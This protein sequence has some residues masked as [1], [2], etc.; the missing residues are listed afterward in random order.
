MPRTNYVPLGPVI[1]F[2]KI[3]PGFPIYQDNEGKT[4]YDLW[5]DYYKVGYRR[6]IGSSSER[7]LSG[8]LLIK[9]SLHIG[10]SAV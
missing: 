5:T 4:I 10:L 6:M 2:K 7:T 9:D 3:I 8:A 1:E